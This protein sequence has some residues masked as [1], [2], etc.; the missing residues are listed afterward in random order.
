MNEGVQSFAKIVYPTSPQ[1]VDSNSPFG[2]ASHFIPGRTGPV[3][4]SK[5]TATSKTKSPSEF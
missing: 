2:S 3:I 4:L 1:S 5:N